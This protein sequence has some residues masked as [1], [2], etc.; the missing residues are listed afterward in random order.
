MDILR[1]DLRQRAVPVIGVVAGVAEPARRVL[2]AVA[3][4]LG[5]QL[6]RRRLLRVEGAG[7][8]PA[9]DERG[10]GEADCQHAHGNSCLEVTEITERTG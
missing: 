1:C 6:R 5:G 7:D 4:I 3:Q 10:K 8:N 9:G 2:Q